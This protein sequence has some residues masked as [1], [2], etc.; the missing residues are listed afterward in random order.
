[1]HE[2]GV[3]HSC[4]FIFYMRDAERKGTMGNNMMQNFGLFL[5]T[6]RRQKGFQVKHLADATGIPYEVLK[7][8][9]AGERILNRT[10]I[11]AIAYVLEIPKEKLD[12]FY[13][14]KGDFLPDGVEVSNLSQEE[15]NKQLGIKIDEACLERKIDDTELAEMLSITLVDAVRL[16]VGLVT[17]TEE[18]AEI[19]S[20][21]LE[22]PLEEFER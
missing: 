9:D 1:M 14:Q 13:A 11:L 16:R 3:S 6:F 15:F 19:L 20:P 18:M 22:I 21:I 12:N 7:S 4:T 5:R 10:E 2:Y 8:A 17:V